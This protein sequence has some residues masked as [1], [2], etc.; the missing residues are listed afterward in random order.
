MVINS[1]SFHSF[2]SCCAL[3]NTLKVLIRNSTAQVELIRDIKQNN[4]KR[5]QIGHETPLNTLHHPT[6]ICVIV[7]KVRPYK[8]S[9]RKSGLIRTIVT[10]GRP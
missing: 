9:D 8:G 4:R 6:G 1:Y 2:S 5:K 10:S 3:Y 7:F